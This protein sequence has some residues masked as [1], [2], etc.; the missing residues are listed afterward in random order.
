M[1]DIIPPRRGEFLTANGEPT[2]RFITWIESLTLQGNTNTTEIINTNV[3]EA[4]P[5]P[6]TE[7]PEESQK[8]TYPTLLPELKRFRAVTVTQSYTAVDHDF[9]NAKQSST[10]TLPQYPEENSVIIVRN[11]DGSSIKLSG[12]GK[13]INGSSTGILQRKTTAIEFYYFIDSGEW[14]AK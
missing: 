12:N 14:V 5:W 3:R 11:G 13:K 1:T 2:Q 4:W 10:I 8:F 7:L 9:I 6:T